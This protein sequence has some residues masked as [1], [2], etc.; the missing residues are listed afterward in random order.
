MKKATRK[1]IEGSKIEPIAICACCKDKVEDKL[2]T[3]VKISSSDV[4]TRTI[5][6]CPT[7]RTRYS[8][9]DF[10]TMLGSV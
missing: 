3:P 2:T 4:D 6:V 9:R 1:N 10:E 8:D 7:C 5:Y